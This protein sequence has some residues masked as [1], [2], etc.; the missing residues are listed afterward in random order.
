MYSFWFAKTWFFCVT[1]AVMGL[2]MQ[3]WSAYAWP[4]TG[5]PASASQLLSLKACG[6]HKGQYI[7]FINYVFMYVWWGGY[8]HKWGSVHIAEWSLS[9]NLKMMLQITGY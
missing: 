5:Q 6:H 4:L 7:I 3:T 1:L 8:A 2:T 9:D